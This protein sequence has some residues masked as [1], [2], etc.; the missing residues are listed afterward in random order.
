MFKLVYEKNFLKDLKSFDKQQA[1]LILAWIKVNLDKAHNPRDKGKA[2]TGNFK[3]LWR[4]RIGNYRLIC[5]IKDDELILICIAVGH[6][7][8][9]YK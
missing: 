5:E 1:R 6:R 8:D 9:V 7:K 4:Y 2:L 3:G